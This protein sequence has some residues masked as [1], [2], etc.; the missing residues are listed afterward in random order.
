[1]SWKDILKNDERLNTLSRI[2]DLV[3]HTPYSPEER[4][5]AERLVGQLT[6]SVEGGDYSKAMREWN[7]FYMR[8]HYDER[9]IVRD[10]LRR[11]RTLQNR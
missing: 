7:E 6:S 1:M 4:K 10:D 5:E 8:T 11:K 3:A 9:G 2:V